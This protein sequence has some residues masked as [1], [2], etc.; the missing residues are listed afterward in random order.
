ML[1]ASQ[2]ESSFERGKLKRKQNIHARA[3]NRFQAK[4]R[5]VCLG[6]ERDVLLA[7][8]GCAMQPRPNHYCHLLNG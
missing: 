2:I 6:F 7:C 4:P 8:R 1:M 5:K 3:G